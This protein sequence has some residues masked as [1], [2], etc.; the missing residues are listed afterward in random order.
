MAFG[1]K[2]NLI[3][4]VGKNLELGKDNKLLWNLPT[5]LKYF[6]NTT[7]GHPVIM[8]KNTYESI[9]KP[10]PGRKNIVLSTTLKDEN[11]I[12]LNTIEDVLKNIEKEDAFIIGGAKVYESFLPYTDNLYLTLVDDSPNADV[13]FPKFNEEDY[14]K[15][16]LS[17]N[18]ENGLN[19]KF[20]IY[21]RK[22]CKEN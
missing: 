15:E 17:E 3:A 16:I 1:W 10:L 21:R 13:Y 12:V 5:D 20:V 4:A 2:T 14:E 11:I 22:K 19:F 18:E 7:M 6:K 8:G 9:G